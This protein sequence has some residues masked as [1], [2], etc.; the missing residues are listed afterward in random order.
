[1][2]EFEKVYQ[3]ESLYRAY[4]AARRGKRWKQ[5]AAK[6]EVNLLE[7]LN[8]LSEQLRTK[9]YTLSPYNVFMVYE[10]KKRVVMS[11]SYKDKVVQHALCDNVLQPNFT[12]S[13]IQDNYASQVGKGTHYG[14]DRLEG[15]MRKFYRRNSVD[16]W[17]LKCDI[18]KYFYSI[19]HDLLKLLIRKR[20]ADPDVIW[21]LDMIIDST[22]G[23]VGIPIG[24]QT[25]QLFALLYLNDMDHFIKEKLGVKFY[26]RYMD[27]FYLIH[28]DK[29][30]LRHCL[31]EI[32]KHVG[33]L[34][35]SLNGKT[36]I[37]PLKNGIDFLGFHTYLTETG[38]VVRKVRRKSKNNARRKLK[39]MRHLLDEGKIDRATVAQS[40]Q[41]WRAHA[42]KG[43]CYHLIHRM[44]I[45]YDKLF[46]KEGDDDA[47]GIK[48]A[49]GGEQG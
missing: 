4:R 24:N 40:Y 25:S 46:K 41:S 39:K 31:R 19:R 1:M 3:F 43:D 8:L 29:E 2:S 42:S 5:A 12:R 32:E 35:L 36:N 9:T 49:G 37:Y 15:F 47:K 38:G 44:D 6:F 22:E 20:I 13:F 30:Y 18:S 34:G 33:A 11:N 27:D 23:N 26:G 17:V 10:P 14:L 28:E 48:H 21:L 45:Y 16:G 7:A